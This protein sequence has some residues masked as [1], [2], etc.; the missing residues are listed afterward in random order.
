MVVG[1]PD[2][3]NADIMGKCA[4]LNRSSPGF[5]YTMDIPVLSSASGVWYQNVYCAICNK[6]SFNLVQMK[7]SL[8][9]ASN[10]TREE[11]CF[12]FYYFNR[13][14]LSLM[15]SALKVIQSKRNATPDARSL[16]G[17]C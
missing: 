14:I 11:V 3:A 2:G 5:H 9:C 10:Y 6:D 12:I 4:A 15:S 17:W 8:D 16:T 13:Q 7:Y 1:C